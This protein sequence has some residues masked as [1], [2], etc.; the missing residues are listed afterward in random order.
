[1]ATRIKNNPRFDDR[2]IEDVVLPQE[3]ESKAA[4]VTAIRTAMR[5]IGDK[6]FRERSRE[7]AKAKKAVKA[8][9]PNFEE[10]TRVIVADVGVIEVTSSER[11]DINIPGGP[12]YRKT[13][14]L[15]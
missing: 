2:R 11:D 5:T 10:P 15:D 1:M 9:I 4:A 7:L 14:K 12:T 6:D 3:G 13:V 8:R